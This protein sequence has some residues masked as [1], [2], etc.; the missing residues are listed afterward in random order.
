MTFN[1]RFL[2]D[3][4]M[5]YLPLRSRGAACL[6]S[7]LSPSFLSTTTIAGGLATEEMM[8]AAMESDELRFASAISSARHPA[9]AADACADQVLAQ[10]GRAP[11]L[12]IFFAGSL[13][14]D[15]LDAKQQS[16]GDGL[17]ATASCGRS[18]APCW[19]RCAP[20]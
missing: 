17:G 9:D 20:R 14:A 7:H 1:L 6:A 11:D 18:L 16:G 19:R 4:H 3:L 13:G 15:P 8:R 2:V 10:L 5:L 12:C